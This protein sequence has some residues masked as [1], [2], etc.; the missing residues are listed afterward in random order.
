MSWFG[1]DFE[2]ALA[3]VRLDHVASSHRKRGS[4]LKSRAKHSSGPL[5]GHRKIPES[6][7]NF[8]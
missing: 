1:S 2:S 6:M 7:R 5:A 8:N 3:L 4:L